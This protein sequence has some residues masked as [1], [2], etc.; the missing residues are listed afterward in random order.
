MFPK[1]LALCHS[2]LPTSFVEYFQGMNVDID[3][4]HYFMVL[5]Y[6]M[7]NPT[8]QLLLLANKNFYIGPMYRNSITIR[9]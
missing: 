3:A 9:G 4:S 5:L 8:I 2:F 6:T 1:F 7:S